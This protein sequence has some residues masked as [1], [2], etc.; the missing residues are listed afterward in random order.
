MSFGAIVA[1]DKEK[2]NNSKHTKVENT[3][4]HWNPVHY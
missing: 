4:K 1:I 3:G 2:R